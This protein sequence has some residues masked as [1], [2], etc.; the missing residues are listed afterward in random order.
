MNDKILPRVKKFKAV[1]DRISFIELEC[2]WFKVVLING[3]A[4]TKDREEDVKNIFYEN[5][6]NVCD[7]KPTSKVKILLRDFNAKIG[8]DIIY[9]PSGIHG[10][11]RLSND[12]GTRLVNF[13][14]TRNVVVSSIT[15]LHKDIHKQTRVSPSEQIK[16]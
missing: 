10:L 7:L 15:L 3:H 12:N 11:H 4:P 8:Q 2:Q 14:K 1:N 9:R 16:N 5:L 13:S 6:D